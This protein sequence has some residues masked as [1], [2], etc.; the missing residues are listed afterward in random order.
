MSGILTSSR[1][2]AKSSSSKCRRASIPERASTSS[3][4]RPSSAASSETRLSGVSSTSR[5]LTRSCGSDRDG[6]I[7]VSHG[8]ADR[9]ASKPSFM[10]DRVRRRSVPF[11]SAADPNTEYREQLFQI[12]GF[13][14]VVGG[15]GFDA[16]GAIALHGLGRQSDDRQ[17]AE[18]WDVANGA[19]G[20]ITVH[21]GH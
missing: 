1:M 12:H 2:A 6:C 18:F 20:L 10:L 15:A 13:R 11:M 16:L 4:P 8:P 17:R 21:F 5:I 9:P 7:L 19:H 14:N 3:W